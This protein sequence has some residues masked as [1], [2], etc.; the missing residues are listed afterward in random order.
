MPRNLMV[1]SP[2]PG[3]L[4]FQDAVYG[5]ISYDVASL[6]RDA[7]ISWP[8]DRV[9]DWVARIG[10]ARHAA[11]QCRGF[12]S[13]YRD[14][15]WMGCSVISRFWEFSRASPSRWQP[16]Y[17]AD[18]PRFLN[19]VRQVVSVDDLRPLPRLLDQLE[20]K[21]QQWDIRFVLGCWQ[22]LRTAVNPSLR[23]RRNILFST[24]QLNHIPARGGG[25]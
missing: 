2:N 17:L 13:F 25:C 4:D 1:S 24:I 16:R 7:F 14:V 23:L 11:C 5:P 6:F 12:R 22:K 19:Y 20:G 9:I 15:E 21:Q 8:E 18:T 10:K 3:V